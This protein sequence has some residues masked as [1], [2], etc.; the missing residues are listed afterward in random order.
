[1]K[2]LLIKIV[3]LLLLVLVLVCALFLLPV[4][5]SHNLS[6]IVNKRDLLKDGRRDRVVFVGGSGL[7]D[8]LDSRMVEE[9]L[10][11]PVVNMG[12]YYGFAVT[13][14][15]H[16][17]TPYLH[18]GDTVVIVPEYGIVFDTPD[19]Q[20]RK[21]VFALAPARNLTLYR[22]VPDRSR[23]FAADVIALVQA[24][25]R[26]F[27]KAVL[28]AVRMRSVTPMARQGYAYYDKYYNAYGDSLR[29]MRATAPGEAGLR[30]A[31]IIGTAA[32]LQSFTQVSSFCRDALQMGVKTFFV[33]PAFPEKE[34][35]RQKKEMLQYETRL[36]RELQCT[37][38]GTPQDYLYPYG[39]FTNAAHHINH[40]ARRIRTERLLKDLERA[41]TGRKPVAL[42]TM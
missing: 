36:R 2:R 1:M 27:P 3:L 10:G 38:L 25:L 33:F 34:Y 23:A 6:T 40:D 26:A 24:K 5:Y 42:R 15:L 22:D 12:L 16:A 11:R 18:S 13:P 20:A 31:D 21:W 29:T 35:L 32:Y 28:E 7:F 4:P 39:Y 9:R 30:S 19:D 14:L 17:I 8:G 41:L 37:V